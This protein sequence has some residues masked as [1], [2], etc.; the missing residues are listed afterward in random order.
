MYQPI[1]PIT[2]RPGFFGAFLTASD[3]AIREEIK[4]ALVESTKGVSCPTCSGWGTA[5]GERVGC[6]TCFG[7][8]VINE[9]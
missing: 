1:N 2:G 9:N 5:E 8:G 3:E 7:R 6:Q 4:Q